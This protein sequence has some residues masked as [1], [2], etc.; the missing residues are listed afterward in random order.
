MSVMTQSRGSE[1]VSIPTLSEILRADPQAFVEK[2]DDIAAINLA[3]AVGL[4][5]RETLDIAKSLKALDAMATWIKRRT[6]GSWS[7]YERDPALF[8]GS[9]NLFRIILMIRFLHVQFRVRYNP[10]RVDRTDHSYDPKDVDDHFIC[11]IL[12][13]KRMGT[14]ATLPVFA[15]A[16]GRRLGYLLKLVKVSRSSPLPLGRR[17]RTVQC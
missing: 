15:V 8:D 13:E 3:C 11:G 2:Y 9:K 12:S 16:I 17:T 7:I 6:A 5:R 10:L 1:T 14:C 4:P